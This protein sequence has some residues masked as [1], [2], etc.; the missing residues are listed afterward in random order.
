MKI[1]T[2]TTRILSAGLLLG[3]SSTG[4]FAED[5]A[6]APAPA[7]A[8]TPAEPPAAPAAPKADA[9]ASTAGRRWMLGFTH[10]NLKRVLVDDGTGRES[11][12][13]Y[14]VMT[15]ENKTGLARD[16]RPFVTA[17]VDTRPSAYVAGGY[18]TALDRIRSQEGKADLQPIESTGWKKG[19]E[20][21]IA[22]GATLHLV[23]IFGPVDPGWAS[24]RIEVHGLV[25]A[26]TTLKVQKY[27]DKQIV[28]EAAYAEHNAKVWTELK[29]A[30]KAS[31]SDLPRP[32]AE[33]QEVRENRAWVIH[34]KRNGDEFRP[35]DDL[36]E[37]VR[38]GWEII[39]EPKLLR[40][41]PA[42]S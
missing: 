36:I 38:E 18:T 22:D 14:M 16:W 42:S 40:T 12:F 27:G 7:P 1:L 6:P 11:A 20:G 21:K 35:D 25:N 41:I 37:F 23:A 24:F 2:Q 4:V 33:Y 26:I 3:L 5:P 9:P 19:D 39:G 31:G 30:A 28:D 17:K 34:Y 10:G 32:T 29:A 8:P 15:V 13:L